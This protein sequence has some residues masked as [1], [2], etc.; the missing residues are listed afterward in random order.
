MLVYYNV[1]GAFDLSSGLIRTERTRVVLETRDARSPPPPPSFFFVVAVAAESYAAY[2]QETFGWRTGFGAG[3]S[4]F[5]VADTRGFFAVEVDARSIF[6]QFVT[7]DDVTSFSV[8][9]CWL[10]VIGVGYV[11]AYPD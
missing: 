5:W 3:T 8:R 1:G 10:V 4:N 9:I 7:G 11:R 6:V 2:G